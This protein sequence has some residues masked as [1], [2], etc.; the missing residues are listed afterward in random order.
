MSRHKHAVVMM[1]LQSFLIGLTFLF[2]E[3]TLAGLT[4][5]G[6]PK[7]GGIYRVPLEFKPRTLDPALA[8]DI[9]SVTII[10]Q[11]FDGL[12]QFDKDLNI[13]PAIAKS[14]RV[15]QDGLTYTFYLREGVR[16]H[17]G[18][19]V[20]AEDWVYSF[21]RIIN[22]ETKSP[23]ASFLEQILGFK[24]F[25][26]RKNDHVN[27]LS[28]KGK[29]IF[30]IKLS[31]PYSPFLSVL[32]MNKFK[33]L[34]K[35]EIDKAGSR[36]G[37]T[38]L[39]TGPFRFVSM[40]EGE[41][42]VLEANEDYFEGK[43]FLDKIIF[44]VFHGAPREKIFKEF[45]EGTLDES[46]IP[47]EEFDNVVQEKRYVLLQKP[48]LS[49][50]FYGFNLRLK[51]LDDKNVRK[52]MN[53]AVNKNSIVSNIHKNHFHLARSIL[54]PGMPGYNPQ[55][56][57]YPFD[58]KQATEFFSKSDFSRRKGEKSL[59]IWSATDSAAAQSELSEVK[60]QLSEIGIESHLRF[61][62][63]W[64]NFVSLLM[65]N[66]LPVFLRAWYADF[67]DPDNFLGTLFHSKSKYNYM[68]YRNSQVDF[69]L[70]QAKRERDYMKRID[71]Y[72]NIEGII[73]EDAPIIPMVH[74]LF[75]VVYQ[76]YV[77]GVEVNALGAPYIP[78]KKIWLTKE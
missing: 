39:G 42:I 60:S 8:T 19:E 1:V 51:P 17:H 33:V 73:L 2:F 4:E 6:S 57:P 9:Y 44:K 64:P 34:P 49:L 54:P 13:V 27:G 31:E 56:N 43:P 76:P 59:D 38:P 36:F 46:F 29:Y 30:E 24:D 70:D 72:R 58:L 12:V 11:I 55:I 5:V 68:A 35:E 75:E 63:N 21:T 26:A 53:F 74:H 20:T 65:E 41:E 18:R 47:S 62:T 32:G 3:E 40:K 77:R 45:K 50:R 15:S 16:F 28:A 10:Q 52:A 78:M 7:M 14:W 25:Q 66:K 69:L 71:L 48:M 22:P 23:A 37:M 61:Q 67:P